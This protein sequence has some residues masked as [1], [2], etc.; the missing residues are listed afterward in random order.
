MGT[1]VNVD[2]M[3]E[4]T[5]PNED[6][7]KLEERIIAY[8]DGSL[9][10]EG[11]R[12]LL[13]EIS[14]SP[15]KRALF[16]AH[17]T[18]SQII[19]RARI[20]MEAPLEVK[21]QIADR[22]PGMLAFIPGFLG[23]A[24]TAPIVSQSTNP[25][26]AFFARMSLTTAVTIGSAVALLTAGIFLSS[27]FGSHTM[28]ASVPAS[29]KMAVVQGP[30]MKNLA[31]QSFLPTHRYY[32]TDKSEVARTTSRAAAA[33]PAASLTENNYAGSSSYFASITQPV[34]AMPVS[35]V[36][37]DIPIRRAEML[38]QLPIVAD[39]GITIRPYVST[40]ER[41]LAINGIK[42]LVDKHTACGVPIEQ[43]R[44]ILGRTH[45]GKIVEVEDESASYEK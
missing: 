44:Q 45:V 6:T 20:P 33:S 36:M 32:R 28:H 37:A 15:E 18:L 1:R 22:I 31:P 14:E 21:Q 23:A 7:S 2:V 42:R 43:R 27:N 16:N 3:K 40:G 8:F 17:E 30:A 38:S 41:L 24:E 39:D 34:P 4:S 19:A 9:D 11:S 5:M 13:S 26:F 12:S 35:P 25:L 29:P 10:N